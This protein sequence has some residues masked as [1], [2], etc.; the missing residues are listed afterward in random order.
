MTTT[1]LASNCP[2]LL[3]N[4]CPARIA[5]VLAAGGQL[6]MPPSAPRQGVGPAPRHGAGGGAGAW[7]DAMDAN[8][9]RTAAIMARMVISRQRPYGSPYF[10]PVASV[11]VRAVA[12]SGRANARSNTGFR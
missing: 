7:A 10:G 6:K 3:S 2:L 12:R 5:I 1:W 8:K 4:R 9:T 11:H